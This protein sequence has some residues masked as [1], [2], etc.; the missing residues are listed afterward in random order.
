M[1][2]NDLYSTKIYQN[3]C[4]GS[5]SWVRIGCG[6]GSNVG[7]AGPIGPQADWTCKGPHRSAGRASPGQQAPGVRQALQVRPVL[8][9]KSGRRYRCNWRD[10][11]TGLQGVRQALQVQLARQPRTKTPCSITPT[12]PPSRA[13]EHHVGTN[14]INSTGSITASGTTGVTLTAGQYLVTFASDASVTA[15]GT[16]GAALA[17]DG[18]ALTYAETAQTLTAAGSDRTLT[19]IVTP[20]AGQI[21]TV[22][23]N[24]GNSVT[25]SNSTLTIVKLA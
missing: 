10:R 21:L 9:A 13:A 4:N 25:Y 20:T 15:A 8:Q 6:C 11:C 5:G 3:G 16:V 18:K 19:A 24:T 12:R 22:R 14:V 23:N 2:D 1:Q 17:L 7:P